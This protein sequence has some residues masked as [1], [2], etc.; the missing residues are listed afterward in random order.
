MVHQKAK[1]TGAERD[2]IHKFWQTGDWAAVRVAGSGSS[3]YPSPD[4]LAA[5]NLRRL[6]IEV[7]ATAADAQYLTKEQVEN[8][9]A[10]CQRYGAEGWI[11]VR[12]DNRGWFFVSLLELRETQGS[13][14]L[15]HGRAQAIGLT[16][17]EM[18]GR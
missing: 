15:D 11:A 13:F 14:V 12:F 3:R 17:E 18:L 7:K 1:G 4:I 6:A 10:F 8:L 2:I 5:N 16:F 9:R